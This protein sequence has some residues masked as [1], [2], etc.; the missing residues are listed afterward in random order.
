LSDYHYYDLSPLK[1]QVTRP[2]RALTFHLY[3]FLPYYAHIEVVIAFLTSQEGVDI[4]TSKS[5]MAE[6][7]LNYIIPDYWAV[8]Y[9]YFALREK[10]REYLT[11]EKVEE[12]ARKYMLDLHICYDGYELVHIL[13]EHPPVRRD[14]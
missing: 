14:E 8:R 3:N 4:I 6:E 13:I 7:I 5:W 2:C 10:L 9:D 11:F 1:A 12:T